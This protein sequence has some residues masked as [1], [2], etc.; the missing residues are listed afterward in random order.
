MSQTV[1]WAIQKAFLHSNRK[2]TPPASGTSK[3][4][5]LLDIADSMQKMWASEPATEW[6]S[7]YSLETIGTVSAT[8]TFD[9]PDEVNY[10]SKSEDDPIRI[11]NG[12]STT[13][14]K[15]VKP[16][17]LYKF[18]GSNVCAQIGRTLKFSTAFTSSSSVLGYDITV[19]SILYTD[20]ITTGTDEIQVTDPMWLA[21]MMA[22]DF[23]RNDVVKQNQYDNLLALADQCMQKMIADNSGSLNE[24]P[25]TWA[26]QGESWV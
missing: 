20:D 5:A 18:Q 21:Y 12:T 6:D 23:C 17:Q 19:P 3:Y 14:Y 25:M 11:T 15:L 8:D 16:N 13:T 26:A 4:E 22:A 24:I 7:L 1:E 9:L 2:A 10:I